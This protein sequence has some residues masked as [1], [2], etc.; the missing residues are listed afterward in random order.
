MG[1]KYI[2]SRGSLGLLAMDTAA[3]TNIRVRIEKNLAISH[4]RTSMS[5]SLAYGISGL[6][7]TVLKNRFRPVG[8]S[9]V[10]RPAQ[11]WRGSWQL[12]RFRNK[13]RQAG[14]W[15]DGQ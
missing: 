12:F 15:R 1:G 4:S 5:A 8:G 7:S 10:S 13:W 11:S 9:R 3:Q 6:N 14:N 2:G